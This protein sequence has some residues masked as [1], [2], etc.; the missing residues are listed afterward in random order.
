[1]N[2]SR[3]LVIAVASFAIVASCFAIVACTSTEPKRYAQGPSKDS[4]GNRSSGGSF[5]GSGGPGGPPPD[6]AGGP[7]PGGQ[8]GP[9]GSFGGQGNGGG[10]PPSGSGGPGGKAGSQSVTVPTVY[11]GAYTLTSGSESLS[12]KNFTT[13][14]KDTSGVAVIKGA[15]LML[16]DSSI[17][18]SGSASS[19]D[20]SNFY[21]VNAGVIAA[22]KGS[23]TL[24][25]CAVK[26]AGD[27]ANAVF[28]TGE[29]SVATIRDSAISTS[30]DSARG[31]DATLNG[32]VKAVNVT[33]STKGAHCA[34]L[35]TDRGEGTI[36]ATRVTGETAGEGSPGIYSTGTIVA[37]NSSF[38]AT[39]SE[40]AVIEGK[41]SITLS[42]TSISGAK[43]HGV[44]LYQSFS[45]D[46]GVGTSVFT[47]D[48]GS[49]S[50]AEGPLFYVTNTRA[51][52]NLKNVRL[53][54][55]SG[56][57]VNVAKDRWG[58]DGENGGSVIV[59]AR[60]QK[61]DGDIVADELS[62]V[63]INLLEGSVLSGTVD[64]ANAALGA[65]VSLDA[66]SLWIVTGTSHVDR[67][68]LPAG[69]LSD[70]LKA[71]SSGGNSV[72]YSTKANSRLGGKTYDLPG[73]GKLV[74]E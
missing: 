5:D 21:G 16:A 55:R 57:F 9:S 17:T 68:T 51:L 14:K 54:G 50:A 47:M 65:N 58:R 44:M 37:R 59:T 18:T 40:A 64:G 72:F 43:K 26:T 6:G 3:L 33:I 56:V 73:G 4:S 7:P 10:Q 62:S 67:L 15:E 61:V 12:E 74:A 8:G 46:A 31:L 60:K 24:D 23:V 69:D 19:M 41:N 63:T 45:G 35:A 66:A 29:G 70:A 52:V 28:S 38:R 22:S 71:I 42:G 13:D 39:G 27:G 49:L 53:E 36:D 32:V 2:D 11:R 25:L 20:A 34:A 30:G 48:G 1:M